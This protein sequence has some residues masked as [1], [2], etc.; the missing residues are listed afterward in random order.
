MQICSLAA[1]VTA[2]KHSL[3]SRIICGVFQ[4]VVDCLDVLD[5]RIHLFLPILWHK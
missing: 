4:F 1:V 2:R 3:C 5:D